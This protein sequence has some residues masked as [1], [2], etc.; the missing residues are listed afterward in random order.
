MLTR[1]MMMALLEAGETAAA[2]N[3]FVDDR[4]AV[5]A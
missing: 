3:L 2:S 5:Y 1:F 4:E